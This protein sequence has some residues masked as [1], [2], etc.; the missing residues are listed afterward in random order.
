MDYKT[1]WNKKLSN[2]TWGEDQV[3]VSRGIDAIQALEIA[4]QIIKEIT[5]QDGSTMKLKD[6]VKI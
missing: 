4:K 6:I 5:D 2:G 1:F 3:I